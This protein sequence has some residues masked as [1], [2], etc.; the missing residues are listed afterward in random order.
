MKEGGLSDHG[1]H[2]PWDVILEV[3][4]GTHAVFPVVCCTCNKIHF[5]AYTSIVIKAKNNLSIHLCIF[6]KTKKKNTKVKQMFY[7]TLMYTSF[8]IQF[9]LRMIYYPS[10]LYKYKHR[11]H[12][13]RS[14]FIDVKADETYK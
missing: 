9:L 4:E 12:I 14:R 1:R 7:H 10:N 6:Y 11:H 5:Y 8:I 2:I 3:R 13:D